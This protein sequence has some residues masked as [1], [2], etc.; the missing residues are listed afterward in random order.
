MLRGNISPPPTAK[1]SKEGDGHAEEEHHGRA[2]FGGPCI[3][4]THFPHPP[5]ILR[6]IEA[7]AVGKEEK[8]EGTK[9]EGG[10][11][12]TVET[13]VVRKLLSL[14]WVGPS[15]SSSIQT[16]DS[17]PLLLPHV[18]FSLSFL[19]YKDNGVAPPPFPSPPSFLPCMPV[20]VA[21]AA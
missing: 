6:K 14:L 19:D 9:E 8:E 11:E 1:K 5:F 13:C 20:R 12:G 18:L 3:P 2:E 17:L 4:T 16:T 7:E 15:A 10:R 21:A